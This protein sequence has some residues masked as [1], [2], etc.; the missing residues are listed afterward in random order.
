MTLKVNTRHPPVIS[1]LC[2]KLD[3]P[4]WNGS[5]CIVFTRCVACDLDLWPMTLKVNMCRPLVISNLCNWVL[6]RQL[7]K[8]N[9]I[10]YLVSYRRSIEIW[11]VCK[12]YG[13]RGG[14]EPSIYF[15][16]PPYFYRPSG[17]DQISVLFCRGPWTVYA[18]TKISKNST[19][20]SYIYGRVLRA[21]IWRSDLRGRRHRLRCEY[22]GRQE[23]VPLLKSLKK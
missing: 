18:V 10:T 12:I 19:Q 6:N 17:T 22:Q 3:G 20:A 21:K 15:T 5:V 11:R 14:A 23:V 16:N 2:T 4:S 9:I 7:L 1:N 13:R 8:E